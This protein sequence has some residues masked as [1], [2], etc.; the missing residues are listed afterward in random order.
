MDEIKSTEMTAKEAKNQ[1]KTL[2]ELFCK[3]FT[4]LQESHGE[5][6]KEWLKEKQKTEDLQR[7]VDTL[8]KHASRE[9]GTV[10]IFISSSQEEDRDFIVKALDLKEEKPNE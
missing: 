7:I 9:R 3:Q 10:C 2:E 5:I 4:E 6:A 1:P 8:K